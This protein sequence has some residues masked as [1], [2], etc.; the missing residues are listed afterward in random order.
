VLHRRSTLQAQSDK[1]FAHNLVPCASV[2]LCELIATDLKSCETDCRH[3]M[4]RF[5]SR[6][7]AIE[8]MADRS[9]SF[10]SVSPRAKA[11]VFRLAAI[12][13]GLSPLVLC[14][15]VL[16]ALGIGRAT[17]YDDP[18]VGFSAIHPLFVKNDKSGRYE[19][20]PSRLEHFCPDSFTADKPADE[21]RIFVLGGSTV[22][23]RPWG[24]ETSFSTWLELSL[25][26]ADNSRRW[27]VVNCGGIS[28]A[29][30]RLVPILQE[31]LNYQPDLVIFCEG[32]NEFLEDRTYG[33][34]KAAPIAMSP[35]VRQ[36]SR[37]RT[38]NV[39]RAS[40]QPLLKPRE[41]PL[42]RPLLGP[43][44][45]ARLDAKGGME[46]YRRD[47]DWQQQVAEHFSFNLQRLV[48][49]A[50]VKEVPLVFVSPVANLEWPPFKP[51]HGPAVPEAQRQQFER[52]LAAA[53]EAA[54][55]DLNRAVALLN[56]AL[57]ID[58]QHALAHYQLGICYRDLGR[59]SEARAS[60]FRAKELDVCPLRIIE[61][62]RERLLDVARENETPIVDAEALIAAHSRSGFPDSQWMIDHVHPTMAGHELIAKAIVGKLTEL[63]MVQPG[64][65]WQQ[66][67]DAA[68]REHLQRLPFVYFERGR[69]RLRSEQGWA[70]GLVKREKTPP[71]VER[72][73]SRAT[74]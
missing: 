41:S 51:E 71:S 9:H 23:G 20:A 25:N 19:I 44:V 66:A 50:R 58:D 35:L 14:E 26:A 49:I 56:E 22:Q 63:G 11:I 60:L 74:D 36:V 67:Y 15:V 52:L 68:R 55:S 39:I 30:Y 12:L 13:L 24:I 4:M 29:S 16:C 48:E 70:R 5:S 53:S 2:P 32:N 37:L 62:L 18:F 54:G 61:L 34:I 7:S 65:G 27:E 57:S 33:H 21:F 43:E 46:K 1:A 45:E 40:V 8:F 73:Q 47:A 59:M 69:D 64:S 17:D 72:Q 42:H 10:R 28:Y 3:A 38:Y 31:V 6:N